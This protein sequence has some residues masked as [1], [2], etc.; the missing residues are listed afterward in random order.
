M[1]QTSTDR[2]TPSRAAQGLASHLGRADLLRRLQRL[3]LGE[4]A[5]P[6]VLRLIE[7]EV[8]QAVASFAQDAFSAS[9]IEEA[10][11]GEVLA[12]LRERRAER[13]RIE[14]IKSAGLASLSPDELE[15]VLSDARRGS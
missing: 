6:R 11:D 9:E 14:A 13:E 15:A 3:S 12:K 8:A 10:A 5:L 7:E 2:R 1:S 4:E